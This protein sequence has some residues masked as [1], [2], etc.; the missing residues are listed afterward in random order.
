[1]KTWVTLGFKRQEEENPA[2][3]IKGVTQ[4]SK[5][6]KILINRESQKYP[7]LQISG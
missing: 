6:Y 4:K 5:E 3:E 1:M 2:K 7:T